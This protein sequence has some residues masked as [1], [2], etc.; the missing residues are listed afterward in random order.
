M[1]STIMGNIMGNTDITLAGFMVP[2]LSS[3][4][5]GLVLAVFSKDSES[6]RGFVVTLAL[7]PAIVSVVIMAV[8]GNIGAGVAVAGAFGLVRF[9][10]AQG[11]AKEI[12]S[13]FLAMAVGML[14]GM[15]YVFYA[16][17][18]ELIML[19]VICLY[20]AVDIGADK[21]TELARSLRITIP[22]DLDY[23]GVFDEVFDEFTS[24]HRLISAKTSGM[25]SV[26]KLDYTLTLVS[27][28]IEKKFIDSLR[29]RNGNLEVAIS[30]VKHRETEGL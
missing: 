19:I 10:S 29:C 17:V 2:I 28:D 25:G 27:G 22:E 5:L 6:S 23:T 13:L 7:L 30:S 9:R 3:L 1:L 4:V 12:G 8:N 14:S 26:F 24:E 11:S 16:A 21:N 18:F 15:G 20:R